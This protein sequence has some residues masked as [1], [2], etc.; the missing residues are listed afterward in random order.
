MPEFEEL[1][2]VHEQFHKTCAAT[3][4]AYQAGHMNEV[5]KNLAE[6]DRLSTSVLGYLDKIKA[7]I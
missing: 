4:R 7:K 1:G 2:S 3:I 6:I 5:E